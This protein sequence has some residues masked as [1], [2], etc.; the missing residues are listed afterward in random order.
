MPF[1]Y[2][3]SKF[4][5]A[6][7]KIIPPLNMYLDG[8]RTWQRHNISLQQIIE[9][10]TPKVAA[11]PEIQKY[12]NQIVELLQKEQHTLFPQSDEKI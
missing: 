11:H 12:F 4:I 8:G 3:E 10:K 7:D 6:L 5:Y 1:Y 2:E 9:N